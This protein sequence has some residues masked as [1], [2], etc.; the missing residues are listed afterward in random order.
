MKIMRTQLNPFNSLKHIF[1]AIFNF[2]NS[3]LYL[4]LFISVIFYALF[5]LH[6][7]KNNI[8]SIHNLY[9]AIKI[10]GLNDELFLKILLFSVLTFY[11]LGIINLLLS[12]DFA[13]NQILNKLHRLNNNQ[14]KIKENKYARESL[15]KSSTALT[16][17]L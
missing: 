11:I 2:V 17:A 10:L 16:Q 3:I 6:L 4:V 9:D 5:C 13:S 7:I 8:D 14:G 15:H 1:S 12:I